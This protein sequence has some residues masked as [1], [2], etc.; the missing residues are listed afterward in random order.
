MEE[1]TTTTIMTIII[2]IIINK[3]K[4]KIA[5][6]RCDRRLRRQLSCM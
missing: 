2:I 6:G 5:G 1:I 4:I 3:K